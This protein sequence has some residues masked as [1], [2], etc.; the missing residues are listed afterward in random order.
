ML[1]EFDQNTMANMTAALEHVCKKIPVD[2][3][4]HDTRKRIADA[5]VAC[6]KAGRRSYVDFQNAGFRSLDDITR[7]ARF[8][9]FGFR[10]LSSI[11]A[12]WLR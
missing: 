6:A 2:K 4:N 7:S 10:W 5:M 3:D 12:S 8:D 1:I 11:G 9:W